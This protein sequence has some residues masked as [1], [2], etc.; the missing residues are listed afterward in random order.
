[1]SGFSDIMNTWWM[2]LIPAA[3]IAVLIYVF[4]PRRKKQFDD[5]AK[6]PFDDK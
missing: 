2:W 1:V 4:N 6:I 5:N 3:F